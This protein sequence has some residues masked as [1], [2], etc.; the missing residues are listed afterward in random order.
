MGLVDEHQDAAA[1]GDWH[2]AFRAAR[3]ILNR[4]RSRRLMAEWISHCRQAL[5]A[6]GKAHLLPTYFDDLS[7]YGQ[8]EE[9][10]RINI[11]D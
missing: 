3:Q 6:S 4:K 5:V 7:V 9:L 8:R 1:R 10:N 11:Q 2:A